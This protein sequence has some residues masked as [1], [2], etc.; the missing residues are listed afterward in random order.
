MTPTPTR[1]HITDIR[2]VAVP[3]SDQDRALEFY[4][5]RLGLETRIDMPYGDGQRWLE[6]VPAGATTSIALVP[7]QETNPAGMDTGIRVTTEDAEADHATLQA[8]GVDVDPEVIQFPVPMF[9]LRDP[10]RNTLY[11]VQRQDG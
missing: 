9:T 6:V 3:V 5:D 7:S 2:T 10:D 1:V 11:V 8:M 4:R